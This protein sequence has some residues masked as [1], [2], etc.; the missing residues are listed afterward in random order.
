MNKISNFHSS[1]FILSECD[2]TIECLYLEFNSHK[3]TGS[4]YHK[5]DFLLC[6]KDYIIME[7]ASFL[8]EYQ[9]YFTRTKKTNQRPKPIEQEYE[10]RIHNLRE[11]I[12]PI[13]ETV[14]RWR[15]IDEYRDNYVAHKNRSGFPIKSLKISSQEPYDA[16][17]KF[18][19]IQ[20]LRDLIHIMFGLISQ[21]FKLE[22]TDAFFRAKSVKSVVNPC[23]NNDSIEKEL[24]DMVTEFNNIS[25]KQGRAY[26]LNASAIAFEP[27]KNLVVTQPIFTHPLVHTFSLIREYQQD[28]K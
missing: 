26:T 16:P 1:L 8:D 21:E 9:I 22:L 23:K 17:R 4:E 20:L 14:N 24:Q 18:F 3:Q 10:Q 12:K 5:S 25:A 7:V 19:E 27:L 13:L 11:V 28:N 2:E 15:D 6:L